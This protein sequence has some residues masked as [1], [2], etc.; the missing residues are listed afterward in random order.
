V[1]GLD[2]SGPV[3]ITGEWRQ[4]GG[5][6][7]IDAQRP[8]HQGMS[9]GAAE[10]EVDDDTR[11]AGQGPFGDGQDP[12]RRAKLHAC[13]RAIIVMVCCLIDPGQ[14]DESLPP[15]HQITP[16][17]AI[18]SPSHV[19]VVVVVV[20]VASHPTHSKNPPARSTFLHPSVLQKPKTPPLFQK[21]PALPRTSSSSPL[22]RS[23]VRKP[24][25]NFLLPPPCPAWPGAAER[26]RT[27]I[28]GPCCLLSSRL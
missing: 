14:H 12:P 8:N 13:T 7:G 16:T 1:V 24:L 18:P 6:W 10:G 2:D 19:V 11:V 27:C 22:L 20:V 28:F 25:T 15:S 26:R 23:R 9:G 17:N 3:F 4:H 5:R 21:Y